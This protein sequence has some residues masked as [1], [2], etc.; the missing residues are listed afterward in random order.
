MY[1]SIVAIYESDIICIYVWQETVQFT[2]IKYNL[3]EKV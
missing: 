2:S 3:R 1:T